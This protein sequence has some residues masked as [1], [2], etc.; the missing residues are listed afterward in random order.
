M[1]NQTVI[2]PFFVSPG[3]DLMSGVICGMPR[4]WSMVGN[5]ETRFFSDDLADIEIDRPIYVT[6]LARGGTTILLEAL[7]E[8]PGVATHRYR[9]FPM[10]MAPLL[11]D[12][13][14]SRLASDRSDAT[15]RAHGDGLM[16]TPDSPEAM[17]EAIWMA[18]FDHLHTSDRCNVL[19]TETSNAAFE[20]FYRDHVRK[21][22]L[23]RDG[24]RYVAKGN[25]NVTRLGYLLKL[26]PDARFVV[27]VR[28]PESHV[29]SLIKQQSLFTKHCANNPRAR[30]HLRRV[31]HFEFGPDRT[32][33]NVGN[34]EIAREIEALWSAGEEVRGWALY[35]RAIYDFVIEQNAADEAVR[36][37]TLIVRYEDLCGAPN[38]TLNAIASHCGL[39][40]AEAALSNFA[41][42]IQAPTYY[43][44]DFTD[45]E[46]KVIRNETAETAAQFSY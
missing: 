34:D 28:S 29:A 14:V 16:V 40:G 38:E 5:A 35:W 20:S 18:Y 1:G 39:K 9:D 23:A 26:F 27:P 44:P 15:E 21:L 12:R 17:E 31:G 42:R 4:F 22:L 6:G 19:G 2:D 24:H 36:N 25:Y 37:A 7:A 3:T 13:V 30:R 46:R 8:T 10:V 43:Q 32:A 41:T 11:S 45:E 33:I